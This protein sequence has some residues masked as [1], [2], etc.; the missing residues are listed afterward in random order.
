MTVGKRETENGK[1][2]TENGKQ[3]ISC[4]IEIATLGR[5]L[6]KEDH[7]SSSLSMTKW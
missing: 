3:Q 1:Q 4:F 7:F 2:G 5:L 6:G